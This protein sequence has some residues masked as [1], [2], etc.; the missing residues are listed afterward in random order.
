M[1]HKRKIVLVQSQNG[2]EVTYSGIAETVEGVPIRVRMGFEQGTT[3]FKSATFKLSGVEVDV[4]QGVYNGGWEWLYTPKS[5]GETFT[6]VVKVTHVAFTD[7][8]N[9]DGFAFTNDGETLPVDEVSLVYHQVDTTPLPALAAWMCDPKLAV[10][11]LD[12]LDACPYKQMVSGDQVGSDVVYNFKYCPTSADAAT[13]VMLAVEN[14][15]A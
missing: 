11:S 8:A 9:T 4:S 5:T 15:W 13:K 14:P 10:A 1:S 12:D 3:T 7:S 2:V 6:F